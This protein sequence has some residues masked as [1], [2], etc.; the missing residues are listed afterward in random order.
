MPLS[1]AS[2][3][4]TTLPPDAA[5]R[6]GRTRLP[7]RELTAAL[8]IL[9]LLIHLLF[10]QVTLIVLSAALIISRVSR[11]RPQWLAGPAALGLA[12]AAAIGPGR[13]LSGFAAAP[14]QV[15]AFLAGAIGHPGRLAHLQAAFAGAGHWLP[16]QV[17]VALAVGAAEAAVAGCARRRVAQSGSEH[18]G[19]GQY[20]AGQYRAGLI[21]AARRRAVA[22]ALSAGAVVTRDGASIGLDRA[23]GRRTGITW[24]Q[25]AAGLLAVSADPQAAAR[26]SFP[27]A[28]AAVRR[29][30][31]VIL[32]DLTGSPWLADALSGVCAAAA[33][34]LARFSPAGPARYEPFRGHPPARAAALAIR[35]LS[36]AGTTDRQRQAGQ[37]C[38]ADAL[39]VLAASP[40][41]PPVL[42]GLVYLLD[43]ARLREEMAALPAYLPHRDALARRVAASA[44]ALEADPALCAALAGQLQR[45]RGSALGRWLSLPVPAPAAPSG[46]AA[47]PSTAGL[48]G[49]AGP[50]IPSGPSGPA[51]LPAPAAQFALAD[52]FDP[53]SPFDAIPFDPA[54][55]PAPTFLP[56]PPTPGTPPA[57]GTLPASPALGA[58]AGPGASAATPGS[59]S[60]PPVLRLGQAVRDRGC[61]LFS[62]GPAGEAAAMA[63]RLA[64]ADLAAVLAGLRDQGLRGDC[65]AWVHGC[66][67]IDR[68]SLAALLGLGAA[69]STA[70][71][72]STASPAAAASLAPAAGLIVAGGPVEQGLAGRLAALP[73]FSGE[74]RRQAAAQALRW[75]AED[76]FAIIER[77]G[78]LRPAG[79]SVPAAW[80][81]LP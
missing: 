81:R 32:V 41:P 71:L 13:A 63:G 53:P 39:A 37:R 28:A 64:V 18:H 42:E 31:T 54:A 3:A 6:A 29:R 77:G 36:W 78:R 56:A 2:P 66:E 74:D 9:L 43:P 25:A 38:L 55:P 34:P 26:V 69:T 45:L 67:A 59:G 33:A 46:P 70:V 44:A 75:Q 51:A 5:G 14:R 76:E 48:S 52:P 80:A 62:L 24:D 60:R 73:A 47:P 50:Y 35:M 23:S 30:M 20:R 49:P 16:R 1:P 21:V 68:P 22:G 11:W 12:W 79:R 27:L 65:L 58:S 17:P 72:L 57:P 7:G 40:A 10:A 19:G 15:G 8:A 4:G 61:A